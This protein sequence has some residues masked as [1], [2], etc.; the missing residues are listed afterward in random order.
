[1]FN[2]VF[3]DYPLPL[4][5]VLKG[6]FHKPIQCL[7]QPTA[8]LQTKDLMVE[9]DLSSIEVDMDGFI[10][11]GDNIRETDEIKVYLIWEGKYIQWS[12]WFIENRVE[13]VLYEMFIDL[14]KSGS[15]DL[16]V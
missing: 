13:D 3:I 10:V 4:P 15:H 9:P 11:S 8:I 16:I 5:E 6:V 12:M 2:K 14:R 7:A 1:M